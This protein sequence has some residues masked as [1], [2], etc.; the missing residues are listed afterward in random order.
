LQSNSEHSLKPGEAPQVLS[1]ADS[2]FLDI[3]TPECSMNVALLLILARGDEAALEQ[4]IRDIINEDSVLMRRLQKKIRPATLSFN[5]PAWIH[6]D[7]FDPDRHLQIHHLNAASD[8]REFNQFV[9]DLVQLPLSRSK[10]LWEVHLI[11]GLQ[12]GETAVIGKVHHALADGVTGI[13][14]VL[15]LAGINSARVRQLEEAGSDAGSE[16]LAA[17]PVQL[18]LAKRLLFS[19]LGKLAQHLFFLN[20]FYLQRRLTNPYTAPVTRFNGM[21]C[22]SRSYTHGQLPLDRIRDI[23][24]AQDCSRNE[25]FLAVISG[26]LRQYLLEH[27]ELP[28]RSLYTGLPMAIIGDEK[29]P[30]SAN[31]LTFYRSSLATTVEDPVK[32]LATIKSRLHRSANRAREKWNRRLLERMTLLPPTTIRSLASMYMKML[33]R[34]MVRPNANIISTL[35]P[36]PGRTAHISG[37]E[38]VGMHPVSV[39]HHGGGLFISAVR[40]RSD[41]HFG[42]IAD[43]KQLPDPDHFADLMQEALTELYQLSKKK[44]GPCSS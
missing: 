29:R 26:A 27:D 24:A 30:G 7:D 32:R 39:N 3:E 16:T 9:A 15:S 31:Q 35:I 18:N 19:F 8:S 1:G 10:P 20:K 5:F 37:R 21:L 33:S 6:D 4:R 23:C 28:D 42:I 2:L 22:A 43:Q 41:L 34:N 11:R 13:Q 38:V 40:Y 12:D 14:M 17:K 44:P 36:G 25:V